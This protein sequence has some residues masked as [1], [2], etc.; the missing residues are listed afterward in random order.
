MNQPWTR[1]QLLAS[2]GVSFWAAVAGAGGCG[3]GASQSVG[4]PTSSMPSP[5]APLGP[6][7]LRPFP[8]PPSVRSE[9]GRL[10]TR[11]EARIGT[12]QFGDRVI[13][14]PT[15]NGQI[16]GPTLRLQPGDTLEIEL[17]N[18]LPL[19][20]VVPPVPINVPPQDPSV[21]NL[22]T[23]GLHVSPKD[24][25]DNVLLQVFSGQSRNYRYRLPQNHPAGAYWYHPHNHGAAAVQLFGGCRGR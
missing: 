14:T 25:G 7:E 16:P 1:R 22:H 8:Q 23:H 9:N 15:Y 10:A 20:T 18:Q 24:P 4:L 2:L 13:S 12:N 11:L 21:T 6:P 19:P 3:S 17:V 5:L